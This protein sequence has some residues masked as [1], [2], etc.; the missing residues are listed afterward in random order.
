[1]TR[2]DYDLLVRAIE[3]LMPPWEPINASSYAAGYY[4]ALYD[5]VRNLAKLIG[6]ENKGFDQERFITDCGFKYRGQGVA[7]DDN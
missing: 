1:M 7:V 5:I 3:P 6:E 2:R 4:A